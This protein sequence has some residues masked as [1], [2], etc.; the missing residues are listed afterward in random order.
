M[1]SLHHPH[2]ASHSVPGFLPYLVQQFLLSAVFNAVLQLELEKSR[3]EL[4]E[5][6]LEVAQLR[7]VSHLQSLPFRWHLA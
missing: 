6:D 3:K 1:V 2:S 5:L 4:E 7:T